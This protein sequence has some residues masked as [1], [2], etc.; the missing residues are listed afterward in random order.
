MKVYQKGQLVLDEKV[1]D[2]VTINTEAKETIKDLFPNIPDK[3]LFKIIKTAFQLG[4]GKVGT[5]DE[6]PLHRRATLSVVA[7]IRHCYTEYD[8]LLRRMPYNNARH[9]V[10]GETL[11][12]LVEWRGDG[13][14]AEG[15]INDI[16]DDVIVISD[17]E[18]SDPEP[19]GVQQVRHDDLR[20][21]ELDGNAYWPAQARPISPAR[22]PLGEVHSGYRY[23]PQAVQPYRLSEAEIAARERNRAARW[24]R[25]Q[26]EYRLGMSQAG[27]SYQRVL[28]REPSP[29]RR[30]IPIDEPLPGRA[31]ERDHHGSMLHRPHEVEVGFHPASV[32]EMLAGIHIPVAFQSDGSDLVQVLSR[33]E[34]PMYP[35]P[36][37]VR[38]ERMVDDFRPPPPAFQPQSRPPTPSGGRYRRRSASPSG[39]DENIVPSIEGP[40][41]G[42][43][44]SIARQ[45]EVARARNQQVAAGYRDRRE[46]PDRRGSPVNFNNA[47][48]TRYRR[49]EG[50]LANTNPFHST[51]DRPRVF[52][53]LSPRVSEAGTR[54]LDPQASARRI[55]LAADDLR[56]DHIR[57]QHPP[58]LNPFQDRNAQE[59]RRLEPL[60]PPAPFEILRR[61]NPETPPRRILEPIPADDPYSDAG[62]QRYREY[63]PAPEPYYTSAPPST[64]T[65][66][67][68][69]VVYAN[70]PEDYVIERP[71]R[72]WHE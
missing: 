2:Q 30:L 41:G 71:S 23:L 22:A 10:E 32:P 6:I 7:H 21:E 62:P 51:L 60:P 40:N 3:D 5:A 25:A 72:Q 18:A 59:V 66:A 24:E 33:P 55:I 53:D 8:R 56:Y 14:A 13:K 4:D 26:Q 48:D 61:P 67:E 17:E 57:S 20:V 27:P 36:A 15:A 65:P 38:Y 11:K 42:Y 45:N 58:R 46:Q 19:E 70:P 16:L 64:Y 47:D 63:V 31:I 50:E 34:S 35:R 69:R 9:E 1:Q 44:P 39:G 52:R 29:V 12:I 28:I 37:G 43:S 49:T 54:P 68:R